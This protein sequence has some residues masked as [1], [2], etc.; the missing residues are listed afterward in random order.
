MCRACGKQNHFAKQYRSTHRNKDTKQYKDNSKQEYTHQRVHHVTSTAPNDGNKAA[1]SSSDDEYVSVLNTKTT[2]L[3]Q[4]NIKLINLS[5]S[6]LVDSGATANIISK[7]TY[8]KLQ[9]RPQLK[10]TATKIFPYRSKVPLPV[11]GAFEG[12]VTK[13]NSHK[14]CSV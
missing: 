13:G 10:Q 1:S 14:A 3:P 4:T 11:V 6:V 9:P 5:V 2:R 12:Q 7:T 8:E